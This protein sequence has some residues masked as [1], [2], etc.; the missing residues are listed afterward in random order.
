MGPD[1]RRSPRYLFFANAEITE[2]ASEETLRTHTS[3]LS[4]HGCYLDTMNPFFDGTALRVRIMHEG[5][6]LDAAARVVHSTPNVGMG[7]SFDEISAGHEPV[8][9]QWITA[10]EAS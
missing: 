1:L 6:V 5:K 4:R 10:L 2:L 7:L 9:E 3:E 8:I